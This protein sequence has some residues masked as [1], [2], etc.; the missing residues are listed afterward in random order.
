MQK[1]VFQINTAV[2]GSYEAYL[3]EYPDY[4]AADGPMIA[5][6]PFSEFTDKGGRGALKPADAKEITSLSLWVNTIPGSEA[7]GDSLEI[8]GWVCYDEIRAVAAGLDAPAF[9]ALEGDEGW[10]EAAKAEADEVARKEQEELEARRAAADGATGAGAAGENGAAGEGAATGAAVSQK[11]PAW[12]YALPV[13]SGVIAIL[14]IA[15]F[16]VLC[17]GR[18]RPEK[19]PEAGSEKEPAQKTES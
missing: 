9:E 5:T 7:L 8:R 11:V 6:I 4:A 10:L 12:K 13:I 2:G 3:Q 15:A 19:K 16:A 17:A 18:R 1:T 14:A